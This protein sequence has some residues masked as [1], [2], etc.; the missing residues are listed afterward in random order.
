MNQ[1]DRR[2]AMVLVRLLESQDGQ[3]LLDL[4][5]AKR[6]ETVSALVQRNELIDIYRTQGE[7]KGYDWVGVILA[8]AKQVVEAR[9]EAHQQ[10]RGMLGRLPV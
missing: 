7:I 1:L 6:L 9:A 4:L 5:A 3:V 8:D 2:Q 10:A